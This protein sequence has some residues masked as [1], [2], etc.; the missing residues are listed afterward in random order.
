MKT[1]VI[2]VSAMLALAG[3][4][5]AQAPVANPQNQ[6]KNPSGVVA[7]GPGAIQP[8]NSVVMVVPISPCPVSMQAKQRGT[9]QMVKTGRNDGPA[10]RDFM[11]PPAQ[12]IH[13]VLRGFAKDKPVTAATVEAR[14]RSG[15][16]RID[17][18]RHAPGD[19]QSDLR[20]TL[21]VGFTGNSDGSVSA[22][23]DL[24]AFT[25]VNAIQLQSITY[26]DGSTWKLDNR[27]VCT[28]APD[29]LM[30]IAGR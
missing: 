4:A 1:L 17:N 22:D 13:L 25:T 7:P 16:G 14:G 12:H 2:V 23:L 20:R 11:P 27:N 6:G 9:T 5:N 18:T 28:V 24:P 29:P 19:E 30:L 3:T 15:R 26:S 10:Q 21:D 8:A